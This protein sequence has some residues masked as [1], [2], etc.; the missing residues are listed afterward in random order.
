[1]SFI[2]SNCSR[3]SSGNAAR[4]RPKL[5][6]LTPAKSV[7]E[8]LPKDWELTRGITLHSWQKECVED[9]FS[10][11]KRGIIKVVTGAGKTMLALAIIE[12]LQQRV[13]PDLRV[14][15]V[16]PT[17]VL[18]DQ[19]REELLAHSNLPETAIGLMGGGES[20]V[21]DDRI[22]ILICVLNSAAKKLPA[23]AN[24]KGLASSLLLVV[25]ECHRAGAAEMQRVFQTDRAF[26]LGLS[27]T[28]ERENDSDPDDESSEEA[29]APLEF[30]DTVLGKELGP[31]VFELN[32][33]EAIR[34]GVLPPFQIL[35]YGL[36]LKPH[37]SVNYERISR[38]IKD[39][40]KELERPGRKGLALIRWC[41]SAAGMRN[42]GGR[43]FCRPHRRKKATP[44]SNGSARRGSGSNPEGSF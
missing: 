39:L 11:G 24:D 17:T 43:S 7:P 38:E 37:E 18:L 10:A 34:I 8:K 25:D 22:R 35:H 42:Q 26:S 12:R 28:P 14:A 15:I 44:L 6:L 4:L 32:Y 21:F 41:R 30:E 36:G 31:V 29:S 23:L 3:F 20:A 16:V 5:N 9:W 1:M 27:A 33:S 40:R 19:W 2:S 13:T